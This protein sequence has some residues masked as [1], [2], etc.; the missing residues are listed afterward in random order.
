MPSLGIF[1]AWRE[2]VKGLLKI[3]AQTDYDRGTKGSDTE[4]ALRD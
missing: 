2:E 1:F 3:R 4:A